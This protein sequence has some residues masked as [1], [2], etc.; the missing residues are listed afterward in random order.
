MRASIPEAGRGGG[1]GPRA[2]AHRPVRLDVDGLEVLHAPA[3]GPRRGPPLVFVHGAYVGAWVWA[4]HFLPWLAARG[5]AGFALSLRGHGESRGRDQ[6]DATSLAAYVEDLAAVVERVGEPVVVVG[7]SM[8]GMVVQRYLQSHRPLAAVLLASVP[9]WGLAASC[10]ELAWR[11]PALLLESTLAPHLGPHAIPG[12]A[13]AA[14]LFSEHLEPET[15]R[16]YLA[17]AQPESTRAMLDMLGL[18]LPWRVMPPDLPLL[19][20]GAAGDGFFPPH[21]VRATALAYGAEMRV[22]E[23]MSHAMMLEPAW[24]DVAGCLADWV[25]ALERLDAADA[26]AVALP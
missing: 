10:A 18:D 11:A 14:A 26:P 2:S 6:L 1:V 4:E 19:V 8:G 17:R 24:C 23:G 9:P 21:V 12:H 13:M 5:L 25:G 20:L 22:F 15:R 7:H 3:R 16:G